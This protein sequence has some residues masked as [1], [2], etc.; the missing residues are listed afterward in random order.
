MNAWID[1]LM[2]ND[3]VDTAKDIWRRIKA[4]SIVA[5]IISVLGL[6]D[7]DDDDDD[8]DFSSFGRGDDSSSLE[9]RLAAMRQQ[10]MY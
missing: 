5:R 9:D 6:S 4:S 1:E 2:E 10:A 7:D 3:V 8:L